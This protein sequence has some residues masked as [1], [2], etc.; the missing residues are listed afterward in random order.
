[1]ETIKQNDCCKKRYETL[2][3][4]T[5]NVEK[6]FR[7]RARITYNVTKTESKTYFEWNV[8]NVVKWWFMTCLSNNPKSDPKTPKTPKWPYIY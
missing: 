7:A 1:M 3:S 5:M 8:E 4:L 6:N 2:Y